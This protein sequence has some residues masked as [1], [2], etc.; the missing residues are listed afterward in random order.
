MAKNVS[1][2]EVAKELLGSDTQ[3]IS[4]FGSKYPLFARTVCLMNSEY[5]LDLLKAI[6][7]V[8][9]RNIETGLADMEVEE[10]TEETAVEETK[11]ETKKTAKGKKTKKEEPQEEIE[12]DA[13][14]TSDYESMTT[15]DLYK[16]CCERGI[17]SKCKDRKKATLV[18]LLKEYDNGSI[19][20]PQE[21][22]ADDWDDEEEKE[23]SY[24]DM[25]AREL[26]KLCTEK[27][28]KTKPKQDKK[29]YIELLNKEEEPEVEDED[30]DDD[31]WEI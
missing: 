18:A 29:V 7:D 14:E 20:E 24:E 17:S 25:S 21:E 30:D 26:Y 8:S 15:K 16:L 11:T 10:N 9:A 5:V 23:T 1:A 4:E 31:D 12:E 19:E 6:P 3:K 27:G 28:I 22:D 13:E 2:Y